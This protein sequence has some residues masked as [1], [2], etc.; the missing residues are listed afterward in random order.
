[1]FDKIPPLK[2][3][4]RSET[5]DKIKQ[6]TELLSTFFPPL[7]AEIKEEGLHL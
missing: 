1:M 7:P 3:I 6:V 2:R 4:D 5:K